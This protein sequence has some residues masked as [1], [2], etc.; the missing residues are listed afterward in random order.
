M[1][2]QS[3]KQFLQVNLDSCVNFVLMF[4]FLCVFSVGHLLAV[5]L[6]VVLSGYLLKSYQNIQI[7]KMHRRKTNRIRER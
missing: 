3:Y 2:M 1:N 4:S 5:V 7:T 6:D